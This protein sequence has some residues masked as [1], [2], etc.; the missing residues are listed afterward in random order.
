MQQN[1]AFGAGKI[2]F[3]HARAQLAFEMAV[4]GAERRVVELL[5]AHG[6]HDQVGL[7]AVGGAI[8]K[9][10]L[11]NGA[12][13]QSLRR[14]RFMNSARVSWRVRKAPSKLLVMT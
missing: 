9:T 3:A 14:I 13:D 2:T 4:E 10:D 12:L 5:V 6:D 11:H 7:D 8:A 1:A